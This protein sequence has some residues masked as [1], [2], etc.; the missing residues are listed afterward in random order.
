MFRGLTFFVTQCIVSSGDQ[1][2]DIHLGRLA[3][4]TYTIRYERFHC[5]GLSYSSVQPTSLDSGLCIAL[6]LGLCGIHLK[7][8]S[9]CV[10]RIC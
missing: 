10:H 4:S 8:A 3:V 9:P 1:T 2:N 7:T 6:T 5:G